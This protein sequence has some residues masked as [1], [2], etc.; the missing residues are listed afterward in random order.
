MKVYLCYTGYVEDGI[1]RAFDSE[2]KKNT[3]MSDDRDLQF[4][5]KVSHKWFE[6]MEVE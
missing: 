2:E 3:W 4:G 5:Q 1:A 6:E